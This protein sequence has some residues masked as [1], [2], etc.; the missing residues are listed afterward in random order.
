MGG[1]NCLSKTQVPAKQQCEVG[2]LTSARCQC[3]SMEGA[4][5]KWER[6]VNGG[7]IP[8]DLNVAKFLGFSLK[9]RMNDAM[10]PS[11]SHPETQ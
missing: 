8:D 7:R 11:L 3:R 5:L 4:S 2:G 1:S 6:L 9:S 10:T